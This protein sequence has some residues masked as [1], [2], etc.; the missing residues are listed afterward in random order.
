MLRVRSG[1]VRGDRATDATHLAGAAIETPTRYMS[2]SYSTTTVT[3][4]TTSLGF[5]SASLFVHW[6]AQ[7]RPAPNGAT[8]VPYK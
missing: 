3:S 4:R 5:H 8:D 6:S 1:G 2:T 7:S